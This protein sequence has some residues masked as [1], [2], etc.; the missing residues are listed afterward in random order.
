MNDDEIGPSSGMPHERTP[1]DEYADRVR[2]MQR[3]RDIFDAPRRALL[4]PRPESLLTETLSDPVNLGLGGLGLLRLNSHLGN[5]RA[6]KLL[7]LLGLGTAAMHNILAR[8]DLQ[9][10][11]PYEFEKRF[12][13]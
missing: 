3:F 10:M 4:G 7:T 5:P 9:P 11:E 2:A 1:Y 6:S 8:R 13:E 12:R